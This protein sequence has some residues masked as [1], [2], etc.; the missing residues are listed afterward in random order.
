MLLS[1]NRMAWRKLLLSM[2]GILVC[3]YA[4]TVLFYIQTIPDIG[5]RTAFDPLVKGFEGNCKDAVGGASIHLQTGDRIVGVGGRKVRTWPQLLQALNALHGR[6]EAVESFPAALE[7]ELT[8]IRLNGEE[9][10]QVEFERSPS[11][12]M[13]CWCQVI[14]SKELVPSIFWFFLKLGLFIVGALVF[15]KRPEDASATHFFLLCIVTLGAYMGGYHWSRIAGTPALI[16]VFMVSSVLSPAVLLNFYSVFPRPKE[17][18]NRYPWRTCLAI[19]GLPVIFLVALIG[20]YAWVYWVSHHDGYPE[21]E[22]QRALDFL[23]DE[24]YVYLGVAFLW[25]L[26][27]VFCLWHSYRTAADSTE[28]NQVKWIFF[29]SLAALVP[30]GKTLE[31][32]VW[33]RDAFGAGAATWWMFAASVCFTVAFIVSITRY[34]LMQLDQIIS[35]SMMYFVVSF[36]AA[37]VYSGVVFAGMLVAGSYSVSLL[38]QALS[39]S[40]TA[41]VVMLLLD[42]ARSRIRRALDQHFDRQKYQ[43]DRT[44]RRMGQAIE[45]LVDPPTLARQLLQTAAEVLAVSRGAVYLREGS[46]PLYRLVDSLGDPPPLGELSSGCPLIEALQLRSSVAAGAARGLGTD[47]VQRQLQFLGGELAHAL[48]HEGQLLA[49]LV[50]GRKELGHYSMEDLNVLAAFAQLTALALKSAERHRTIE[51]LNRELQTKVEKISEQ[52]RRILALQSQLQSGVRSQES[53]VRSQESGV[54]GQGSGASGSAASDSPLTTQHSPLSTHPSGIIGSSFAVQQLLQLVKKVSASQSAVLVRGESGTGKELLARAIHAN[55]P[56]AGKA[57]VKVHCAALSPG[58]LESEL[59]GHVKG[60]FTGAH[61]DKIGRFELAHGGTLFLDEIGD[62][63]L[64]VQTKLLRVLQEM[65]FERVGSSEPIQV[66]VRVIAATH[67]N[68]EHLIKEGRFREDLYYRLNV[69]SLFLPP[70]RERREDIPELALHFLKVQSQ[71]CAR[72]V[73]QIDDDALVVFKSY[74]WPGNVRQ[75]EN[76]IERAVVVAEG[77]R[78]T[79]EDLPADIVDESDYE[80]ERVLEEPN[81]ESKSAEEPAGRRAERE[82]R[83][84]QERE[85]LVRALA[86]ANGNKAE[87][88]RVLGLARSTLVSRLKKHGLS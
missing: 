22:V 67:Q 30:I 23:L 54:K 29:G 73:T 14:P 74:S 79:V 31:L 65:V 77:P 20:G 62:I 78:I 13:A 59:F 44:F 5:L 19:F 45:Q 70:L 17:Y 83:D 3:L 63:S 41:V 64:E 75:L 57:F 25:Y 46:P 71:R 1:F 11:P 9:W 51:G 50:L 58:L 33:E 34:R 39:V 66:D 15:W 88:A 38:A 7:R 43:L 21:Q 82:E 80:I 4:V 85:R 47:P 36:L 61:R 8:C 81:P 86:A 26:A 87:A 28:R 32:A 55:S 60:A 37:L 53:G 27:S 24:I 18:R 6:A 16:L 52:Q 49:L 10:V 35:S 2:A 56:R 12:V 76:V 69:I 72:A 84:R 68:L 42:L 48:V 40:T